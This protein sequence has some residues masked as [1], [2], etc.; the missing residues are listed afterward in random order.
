VLICEADDSFRARL[1]RLLRRSGH[2]TQSSVTR[3]ECLRLVTQR[4]GS[5]STL[6]L[7]RLADSTGE[8]AFLAKLP[9]AGFSGE[10]LLLTD[11]GTWSP[12]SDEVDSAVHAV[13]PRG[14]SGAMIRRIVELQQRHWFQ[15]RGGAQGSA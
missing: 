4:P 6:L 9:E 1:G 5:H 10:I 13:L 2:A 15:R 14:A 12:E 8:A 11:T 7:G 3:E